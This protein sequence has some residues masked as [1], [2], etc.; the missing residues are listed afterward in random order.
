MPSKPGHKPIVLFDFVDAARN[1]WG[2]LGSP[3]GHTGP[4]VSRWVPGLAGA[5]GWTPRSSSSP[6]SRP[7]ATFPAWQRA[8]LL[9]PHCG[10]T[11]SFLQATQDF[12]DTGAARLANGVWRPQTHS[13]NTDG[14]YK[15]KDILNGPASTGPRLAPWV[16]GVAPS[17]ASSADVLTWPEKCDRPA[18]L[19]QEDRAL[20]EHQARRSRCP[21]LPCPHHRL[22][23]DKAGGG[24]M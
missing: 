13:T 18:D 11:P 9:A 19:P 3:P 5:V 6:G 20:C 21:G 16:D 23:R 4:A 17:R 24:G 22:F 7:P 10:R 2:I 12:P 15:I 8:S 14:C 1:K